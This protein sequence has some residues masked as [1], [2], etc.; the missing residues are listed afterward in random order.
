MHRCVSVIRTEAKDRNGVETHHGGFEELQLHCG[1]IS[2]AL[3]ILFDILARGHFYMGWTYLACN[4][5][6]CCHFIWGGLAVFMVL[7]FNS[8]NLVQIKKNA[9][10][11][12]VGV[13]H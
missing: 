9:V 5:E 10:K 3:P 13:L 12:K 11:C 4:F 6:F 1:W 2:P 8:I 7:M